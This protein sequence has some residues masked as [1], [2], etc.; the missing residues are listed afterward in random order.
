MVNAVRRL[1]DVNFKLD[2]SFAFLR[3][4]PRQVIAHWSDQQFVDFIRFKDAPSVRQL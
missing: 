2:G 4:D 3:A 1:R